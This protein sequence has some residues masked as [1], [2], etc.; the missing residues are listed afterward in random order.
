MLSSSKPS[1]SKW[2]TLPML[3]STSTWQDLAGHWLKFQNAENFETREQVKRKEAVER[4]RGLDD[5]QQQLG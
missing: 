4:W 5:I 2:K 3:G 1:S